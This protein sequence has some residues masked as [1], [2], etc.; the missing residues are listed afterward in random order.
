MKRSDTRKAGNGELYKISVT[1]FLADP[2][3]LL[4][5]LA[6][7]G[8]GQIDLVKWTHSLCISRETACL[9][10]DRVVDPFDFLKTPG[11]ESGS[12]SLTEEEEDDQWNAYASDAS[13]QLFWAVHSV[14]KAG[15]SLPSERNGLDSA[16][17]VTTKGEGATRRG[18]TT[19]TS[20]YGALFVYYALLMPHLFVS[21]TDRVLQLSVNQQYPVTASGSFIAPELGAL[22]HVWLDYDPST[23][24]L[25]VLGSTWPAEW[26]CFFV[27]Y[28]PLS[29]GAERPTR[30]F[31]VCI[32]TRVPARETVR[33]ELKCWTWRAWSIS[34][35]GSILICSRAFN[36]EHTCRV[37]IGDPYPSKNFFIVL[38]EDGGRSA[39]VLLNNGSNDR[40]EHVVY[41]VH[42]IG[43]A[44]SYKGRVSIR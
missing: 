40:I 14:I 28:L 8:V 18:T 7:H 41:G 4:L 6:S 15:A 34:P 23:H 31:Q 13:D 5:T 36:R 20:D 29:L 16:C 3:D 38:T 21:P 12:G 9:L 1:D 24:A 43:A 26:G 10:I 42:E 35:S 22:P 11:G 32:N 44:A 30:P 17:I 33:G 19:R 39:E 37:W 2:V 27:R 25:H